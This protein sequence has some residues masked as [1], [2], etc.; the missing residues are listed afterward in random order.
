MLVAL[1]LVALMRAGA[2]LAGDQVTIAVPGEFE[3][4]DLHRSTAISATPFVGPLFSPPLVAIPGTY[5]LPEPTEPRSFSS[6]DFRPRGRS[7]F[8]VDPHV[9]AANDNL[10]FDKTIWQRLNE[11]R[12]RDQIRVLTLWESGASAVSIQ[13]NRKGDPY[14]QWTSRLMNRGGATHGLLDRLFSVS[15]FSGA[16]RNFGHAAVS[17]PP[18]PGT[19]L[20][21]LHV[22]GAATP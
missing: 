22:A 1:A 19:G 14:L 13:T 4:K 15:N 2:A 9:N 3:P 11:Y 18:K 8:D 7:V 6:K 16:V 20:G 10:Q 12:N 5:W 17:P 21:P